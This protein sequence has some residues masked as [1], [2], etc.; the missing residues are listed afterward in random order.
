MKSTPVEPGSAEWKE[1]VAE[2]LAAESTQSETLWYIS[3]ADDDA[4]GFLG[5]CCVMAR[6]M[7][8]AV[9]RA[10]SLGI[11]PGGQVL[12]IEWDDSI[13]GPCPY[14][15]DVL[16]D[17]ETIKRYDPS[18]QTIREFE[19]ESGTTVELPKCSFRGERRFDVYLA[20]D[21][22][23]EMNRVVYRG[24]ERLRIVHVFADEASW[25][26]ERASGRS[27]RRGENT[28]D[29]QPT[30]SPVPFDG[31]ECVAGKWKY[32]YGCNRV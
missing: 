20:T 28:I 27:V 30:D 29:L 18:A 15:M 7:I 9:R 14:P 23:L 21:E 22:E 32:F 26:A 12:A 8:G 24:T 4:G 19:E 3:F 17:S 11:N 5:A 31:V 2:F 13:A 25:S 1:R 10:H 6:G 16:M